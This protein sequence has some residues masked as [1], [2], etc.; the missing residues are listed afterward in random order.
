MLVEV[1]ILLFSQEFDF[2][3][4]RL[5][6]SHNEKFL[7]IDLWKEETPFKIIHLRK[8]EY[9]NLSLAKQIYTIQYSAAVFNVKYF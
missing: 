5:S 9:E 2:H 7:P 4:K 8:E 1:N 6:I 3:N